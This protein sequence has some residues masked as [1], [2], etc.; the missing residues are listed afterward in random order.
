MQHFLTLLILLIDVCPVT[1]LGQI[2]F[3]H[4]EL[5]EFAFGR[6]LGRQY[7]AVAPLTWPPSFDTRLSLGPSGLPLA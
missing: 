1:Q 7:L 2:D 5:D 4:L 6:D 3:G